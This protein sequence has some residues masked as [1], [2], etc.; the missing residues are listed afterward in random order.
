MQF[1]EIVGQQKLKN[2]LIQSVQKGR[3]SHAQLFHGNYGYG[4]L[5]LAIAYA[6]YI[7]CIDKQTDD[8]C[9]KCSSCVKFNKLSHPDLHFSYPTS[10]SDKSKATADNYLPEWREMVFENPYFETSDWFRKMDVED[11]Q[12]FIGVDEGKRILKVLSLKAY[13]AKYKT[14]IIWAADR[15]NSD[16]CNK[17]LKL[18][19]EP[20]DNT[21]II[22]LTVDEEQLLKTISSRTQRIHIPPIEKQDIISHLSKSFDLS[23]EEAEQIALVSAGDLNYAQNQITQGEENKEFIDW[24]K[25]WMRVCYK[26]DIQGMHKWV[27]EASGRKVGREKRKRFILFAIEIMREALM[28]NYAGNALQRMYGEEDQFIGKFAPFVH[29]SNILAMQEILN[30]AHEHI[31]RNASAKITFMDLSM[32]FANLLHVKNVHL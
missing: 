26:A 30:E 27:E 24:F 6:Q 14:F 20:N 21:L 29:A 28:R 9:G 19:E 13:E 32:K 17:L 5:A 15:M 25:T 11:K 10:K 4:S 12:G 1:K 22:L 18:I 8:S 23:K 3:V 7:S 16:T 2:K 31:S